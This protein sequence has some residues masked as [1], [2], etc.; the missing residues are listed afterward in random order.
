MEH[1]QG[2]PVVESENEKNW[3]LT[4]FFFRSP[5]HFWCSVSVERV[6]KIT[7]KKILWYEVDLLNEKAL[8][9]VFQA[10]QFDAVIHFAGLKAV[11]ESVQK[12]L[13]SAPFA[14]SERVVMQ[15]LKIPPLSC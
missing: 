8:E 14:T 1:N 6:E 13:L 7:G 12:P 9:A 11:G 5:S 15:I 4:L 10:H 2:L 3:K